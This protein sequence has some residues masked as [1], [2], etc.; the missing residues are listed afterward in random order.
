MKNVLSTD[1]KNWAALIIRLSVGI[2][3]FPHGSQKLFGWFNGYGFQGTMGFLTGGAHLPW[4]IA[5]L[6]ILIESIGSILLIFGFLSRIAALGMLINF[7][8]ILF[9]S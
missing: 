5:F 3:V 1:P 8:G 4:I 7:L 9:T 6:V 2:V